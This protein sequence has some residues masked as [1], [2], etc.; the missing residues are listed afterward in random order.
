MYCFRAVDKFDHFE[1][2]KTYKEALEFLN[3]SKTKGMHGL[4]LVYMGMRV[5]LTKKMCPPDLVQEAVGIAV[6]IGFH[7]EERFGH[8][9]SSPLRPADTHNCW[10][11]GWVLCDYLPNYV[12]IL[13]DGCSRDYT[14]LGRPGVWFVR[15]SKDDWD[16]PITTVTKTQGT[17]QVKQKANRNATI[18]VTRCQLAFTHE[19]VKT[20]QNIQGTTVKHSDGSPKGLVVDLERPQNM[21]E[22]EYFQHVYMVLGRARKLDDILIRN[23][24]LDEDG[25]YDWS[26][27]QKG[28]PEYLCE[29]KRELE[30]C[31]K[32][33]W[34]RLLYAQRE[35]K[36]PEFKDLPRCKPDPNNAGRFIYEER[37]DGQTGTIEAN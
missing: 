3:L 28:P 34:P 16:L 29:F 5:R 10:E 31:A 24:P 12:E 17:R 33:T 1:P 14:G 30:L 15:P 23:F 6:G 20:Y 25:E 19:N 4:L 2:D 11:R 32:D 27:F 37:R 21:G 18:K 7:D 22:A 36:M 9:P 8:P 26:M 13:F 35:S